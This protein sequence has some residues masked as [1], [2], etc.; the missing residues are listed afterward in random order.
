[1][2]WQ[3]LF[4][5][6]KFA[7]T[8]VLKSCRSRHYASNSVWVARFSRNTCST[9]VGICSI[10]ELINAFRT[11]F[12]SSRILDS[13]SCN[14]IFL[15]EWPRANWNPTLHKVYENTL[16]LSEEQKEDS[17]NAKWEIIYDM[18]DALQYKLRN[19][20]IDM[21]LGEEVTAVKM[22]RPGRPGPARTRQTWQLV[23]EYLIYRNST[24]LVKIFL[25]ELTKQHRISRLF[26]ITIV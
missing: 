19:T 16:L 3:Y 1:M 4:A 14:A 10:N 20:E 11:C 5:N 26:K 2:Q 18:G 23:G 15:S 7:T 9:S 8:F 6:V 22:G 17:A 13:F 21:C 25:Y 12:P 24:A